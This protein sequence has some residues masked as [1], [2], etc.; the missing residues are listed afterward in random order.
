ME[1]LIFQFIKGHELLIGSRAPTFEKFEDGHLVLTIDLH[2][3][4]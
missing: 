1:R 4:L 3:K 2:I